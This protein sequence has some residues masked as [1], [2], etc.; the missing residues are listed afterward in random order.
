MLLKNAEV[1]SARYS[2]GLYIKFHSY[3]ESD[4]T[5]TPAKEGSLT[6]TFNFSKMFSFPAIT[7]EHLE[8]FETGCLSFNMYGKQNDKIIE[9]RQK[10]TT[11]VFPYSFGLK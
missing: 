10:M 2:F 6:P 4:P 9:S 5:V 8:W 1:L 11:K 3:R 7:E